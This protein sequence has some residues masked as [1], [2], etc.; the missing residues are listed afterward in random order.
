MNWSNKKRLVCDLK[1]SVSLREGCEET[2]K[3]NNLVRFYCS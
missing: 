1:L 2:K 3:N